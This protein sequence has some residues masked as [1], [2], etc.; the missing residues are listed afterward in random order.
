MGSEVNSNQHLATCTQPALK[1][2]RT[3]DADQMASPKKTHTECFYRS[4]L[5]GCSL[6]LHTDSEAFQQHTP[7]WGRNST[8]FAEDP[9]NPIQSNPKHLPMQTTQSPISSS[10]AEGSSGFGN[11][12]ISVHE[13]TSFRWNFLMR[14]FQAGKF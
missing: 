5:A 11:T 12:C 7:T 1:A 13:S 9:S 8:C 3:G 4:T 6:I 14:G 2:E 10:T